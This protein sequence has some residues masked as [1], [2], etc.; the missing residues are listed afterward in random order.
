MRAELA[1]LLSASE[2][3][4]INFHPNVKQTKE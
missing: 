4:G 2:K 3:G 1:W